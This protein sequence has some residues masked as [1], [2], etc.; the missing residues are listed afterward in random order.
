MLEI[1][2]IELASDGMQ[3]EEMSL[4]T[5]AEPIT[6]F[7]L[8]KPVF[9][10]MT[11]DRPRIIVSREIESPFRGKAELKSN[12]SIGSGIVKQVCLYTYLLS[13]GKSS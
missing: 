1:A 2:E 13:I 10:F 5:G 7:G 12:V 8:H 3:G 11:T 6:G 4:K 9:P